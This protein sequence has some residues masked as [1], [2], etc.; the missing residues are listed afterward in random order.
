MITEFLLSLVML[1]SYN[2]G[3]WEILK[4]SILNFK[5]NV[6]MLTHGFIVHFENMNL[7]WECLKAENYLGQCN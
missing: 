3:E 1:S 6:Y 4:A 5:P 7:I 2:E